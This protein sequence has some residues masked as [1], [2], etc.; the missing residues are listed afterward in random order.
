MVL[1]K[2]WSPK[3]VVFQH[4]FDSLIKRNCW[5]TKDTT[6]KI[7]GFST[8]FITHFPQTFVHNFI[9]VANKDGI[10]FWTFL[11]TLAVSLCPSSVSCCT[12]SSSPLVHSSVL[13]LAS[14]NYNIIHII[15][16]ILEKFEE[17]FLWFTSMKYKYIILFKFCVY[18]I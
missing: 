5:W 7:K 16:Q 18:I 17:W 6:N 10:T 12:E 14:G 11:V 2:E 4:R 8:I 15:L 1:S 3:R 13:Q 9:K